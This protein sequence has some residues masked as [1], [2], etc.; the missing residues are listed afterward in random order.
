M[1]RVRASRSDTSKL[2]AT[3]ADQLVGDIADLG[4]PIGEVVG[5]ETELLERYGVS[6]AVFREAVRLV[7]HKHVA[8]MRR[9][10][11]GGLVVAAPEVDSVADAACIYLFYAGAEID[12]VFEARIAL[13]ATAAELAS[14]RLDEQQIDA[15]RALAARERDGTVADHR[16][17]HSLIGTISGNPALAFFIE[18]LN[19]VM[20]LFLPRGS[21]I[22]SKT[23]EESAVAHAGIADAV[24]A[25]DAGLARHRMSVHLM[26]EADYV[27]TWRPSRERLGDLRD[28]VG[29]SDKRGEETAREILLEVAGAGWPVGDQIGSEAEL[30]DRYDISRAVLREAVRVLEH[31]QVARMRRGPGGGLIVAEPGVEATTEAIALQVERQGIT[32]AHLFEVRGAV[33]MTVLDRVMADLDDGGAARL[34]TAL[35]AEQAAS[36]EEFG[37]VG[38]D[39]HGVLAGVAGNQVLELLTL[40]LLLLTRHHMHRPAGAPNPLEDP[41]P[42]QD[43]M[44]AHRAVVDAILA[45]DIGLARR[46]MRRHLDALRAWAR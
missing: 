29:R 14:E 11:G 23:L 44:R 9:G 22:G 26:A 19:R 4:W 15:L 37:I 41:I 17:L 1:T 7:E 27:R 25:G 42:N 39:L 38:H 21:R 40:V 35:E 8:Y 5:S 43:V 13:E 18:L 34:R 45:Q 2:A 10:P 30:M 12:E 20:M 6:R 31:H 36:T 32:P 33:E 24:I 16:E 3:V 46:R 28:V